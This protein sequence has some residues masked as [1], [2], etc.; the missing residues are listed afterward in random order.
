MGRKGNYVMRR[1]WMLRF[2]QWL[3]VRKRFEWISCSWDW[4]F[5]THD[6]KIIRMSIVFFK[7]VL[8]FEAAVSKPQWFQKSNSSDNFFPAFSS[9]IKPPAE[10]QSH[11]RPSG[12]NDAIHPTEKEGAIDSNQGT[13]YWHPWGIFLAQS[14]PQLANKT[15]KQRPAINRKL[16]PR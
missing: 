12:A 7:L 4:I 11:K 2:W 15:G 9:L 1:F 16:L 13:D 14:H 10:I 8:N 5:N 3:D 6:I